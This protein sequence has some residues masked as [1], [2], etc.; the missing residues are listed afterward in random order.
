MST[1]NKYTGYVTIKSYTVAAGQTAT[2]GYMAVLASD[3]TVQDGGA[4]SDLGIGVFR[5]TAAAAARVEVYL[6]APIVDVEVGTGGCTRGTKAIHV[7]DGFT[8]APAH[9]S[10]GGTDNAIYGVFTE[11]GAAGDVRGMMLALGNRGSA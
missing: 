5:H 8:D 6:F 3:T 10:S 11:S 1:A 2:R 9:D 4:S 7:A